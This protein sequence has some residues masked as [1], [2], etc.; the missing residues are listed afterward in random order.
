MALLVFVSCQ[1]REEADW[2]PS[3]PDVA[4]GAE[5]EFVTGVVDEVQAFS[6]RKGLAHE[7]RRIP[8]RVVDA[9]SY[10]LGHGEI[11]GICYPARRPFIEIRRSV[12]LDFEEAWNI[13]VH[14]L[15]HCI[16]KRG[17]FDDTMDSGRRR[18]VV[19]RGRTAYA[20]DNLAVSVMS[21]R[22]NRMAPR[23]YYLEEL[24]GERRISSLRDLARAYPFSIMY[25]DR[26]REA[27]PIR[28][29]RASGE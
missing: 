16:L 3:S 2:V 18:A 21:M 27:V 1:D 11:G 24:F 29:V 14:E 25:T 23:S 20:A 22:G 9:F 26:F 28:R 6:R 4:T 10:D 8:I 12:F 15:G 17:H 5:R 19:F 7:F 13:I